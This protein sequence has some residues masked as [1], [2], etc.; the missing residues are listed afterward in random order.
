VIGNLS[1]S[2]FDGRRGPVFVVLRRPAARE[3][4]GTVLFVPPFAEE[5]NKS[6]RV[7]AD[8]AQ[9]LEQAGMA[10]VVV[11]FYGTGDSAGE[12]RDADCDGW[13]DDLARAADWSVRQG[14]PIT[15]LLCVRLGCIL[16]ARAARGLEG[17]QRTIFWQPV[18][19]GERFLTQFLRLRVAASMM[20][21]DGAETVDGLRKRLAEGAV[22]EIGG[23]ELSP[24][25]AAQ[26]DQLRLADELGSPLG[27]LH[28]MEIVRAA[29]APLPPASEEVV[30]RSRSAGLEP[31]VRTLAG[32]PYWSSTEIVRN[33]E[34]ARASAG[35]LAAQS[36]ARA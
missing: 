14:L 25:L 22:L 31:S 29:G 33:A 17:I 12:F 3:P 21:S 18:T 28:W 1:A 15:S 6:R 8:T 11:D 24:R 36:G 19:H 26:I 9:A 16:G 5:M 34:L 27:E 30:Q 2:F 4:R 32:E 13:L 10:S 23:Y 20:S 7:L 35:V